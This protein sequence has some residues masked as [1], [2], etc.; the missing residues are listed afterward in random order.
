[1]PTVH[2][3]LDY[4]FSDIV[5]VVGGVIPPQD[6][7]KL[8]KVGVAA[9]FGPGTRIPKAASDVLDRIQQNLDENDKRRASA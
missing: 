8:F 6:Y 2:P 1:L 9:I 7:E 3:S 4:S 5:V